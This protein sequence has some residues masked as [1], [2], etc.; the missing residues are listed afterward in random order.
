MANKEWKV[1]A[2]NGTWHKVMAEK[3]SLTNPP[4]VMFLGDDGHAVAIFVHPASVQSVDSIPVANG[5]GE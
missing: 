5:V 1:Q 2:N 3:I 4:H